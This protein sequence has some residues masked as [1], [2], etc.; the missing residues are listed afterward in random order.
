MSALATIPA[1][2]S[3]IEITCVSEAE[4]MRRIDEAIARR[5]YELFEKHGCAPW[6]ELENWRQAESE[7]S[8]RGCFGL[9]SSEDSVLAEC[10]LA[11]F[12]KGTIGGLG[13]AAA[14]DDFWKAHAQ[15]SGT[16]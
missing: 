2:N 7:I 16:L 4:Q 11:S 15:Q 9:T 13:G 8:C 14:V 1:N 3:V 5:A 12:E 10:N 6:H